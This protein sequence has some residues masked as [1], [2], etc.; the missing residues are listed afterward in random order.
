VVRL[1]PP[2]LTAPLFPGLHQHLIGLLQGLTPADWTR[3]TVAGEWAVRDV[4]AHLIDVQARRLSAQ[5]DRHAEP[6]E[7]DISSYADLVAHL[8]ALNAAWVVAARRLSPRILMDLLEVVGPQLGELM[9]ELDPDAVARYPVA[10]AGEEE[11]KNWFDIGR[12][13]TELWHHQ[14]QIRAAVGAPPLTEREWLN[15][16][17]SLSLRGLGRA[18]SGVTPS[19]GRSLV[20]EVEGEAGGIWSALAEDGEWALYGGEVEDASARVTLDADSAWRLFFN[21]LTADDGRERMNAVGD[22]DLVVAVLHMRSVMV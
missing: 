22:P 21:A 9:A 5:R 19:P 4:V 13:Y 14:A 20:L 11:S 10:W 8:D 16:V 17:L 2:V 1:L 12:D 15:P 7:R 18:L 3:P 6:P